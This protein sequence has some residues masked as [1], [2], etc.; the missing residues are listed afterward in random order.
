LSST[1]L[2]TQVAGRYDS[3]PDISPD[4]GEIAFSRFVSGTGDGGA[5]DRMKASGGKA[6]LVTAPAPG[7]DAHHTMPA[8][9]PDGKRIAYVHLDD[10]EAWGPHLHDQS[11]RHRQHPGHVS[12]A[13]DEVPDWRPA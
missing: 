9:S 11:R 7:T 2:T 5:I 13:T 4:G 1:A 10:D 8:W 3:R 6:A 12:P